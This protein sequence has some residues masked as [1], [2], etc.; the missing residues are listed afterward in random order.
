MKLLPDLTMP[1]HLPRYVWPNNYIPFLPRSMFVFTASP[2][3]IFAGALM[4]DLMNLVDVAGDGIG[5]VQVILDT[6]TLTLSCP[7]T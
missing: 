7:E 3:P 4:D 6:G 2:A 1:L 5:Y